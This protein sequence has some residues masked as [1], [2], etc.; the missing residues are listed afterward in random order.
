VWNGGNNN[1]QHQ[2]V[3]RVTH[4]EFL[5]IKIIHLSPTIYD[6]SIKINDEREMNDFD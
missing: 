4:A 5:P 1:T 6:I 3:A 2:K